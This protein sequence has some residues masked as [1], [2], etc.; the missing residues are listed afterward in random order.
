MSYSSLTKADI[1]AILV[2]VLVVSNITAKRAMME[3]S[4][5][6]EDYLKAIFVLGLRG[7]PVRIKDLANYLAVKP[8][9]VVAAIKKLAREGL[10]HH[11]PY[12]RIEL[13]DQG[14]KIAKE[15]H[16]RYRAVVEFLSYLL[17][18][19]EKTAERDACRI[20]HSLSTQAIDQI[21]KFL[22]F[23][24]A[25]P[26]SNPRCLTAFRHY[27]ATNSLPDSCPQLGEG[28]ISKKSWEWC[29]AGMPVESG[30]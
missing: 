14:L 29:C 1:Y 17:G 27:A 18:L 19:D 13:T 26:A 28:A 23:L 3:L 16:S 7:Q 25:C 6:K 10:V 8:P 12:G 4:P 15:I 24:K 5:S 30:K 22:Q 9:S 11:E 21:I 20:E 2:L